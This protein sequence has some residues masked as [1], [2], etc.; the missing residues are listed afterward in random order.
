MYRVQALLLTGKGLV[1]VLGVYIQDAVTLAWGNAVFLSYC[2]RKARMASGS[3]GGEMS[4]KVSHRAVSC[5]QYRSQHY[6]VLDSLFSP[7]SDVVA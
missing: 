1:Q 7:S 6:L 2:R 3:S 5:A 4:G